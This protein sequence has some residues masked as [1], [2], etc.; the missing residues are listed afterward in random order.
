MRIG[1]EINGVLRNTIGKIEQTYQKFMIDKTEGIE[2]ENSFEYKLSL[3]VTSL[4]LSEHFT[5]QNE[6]EL[7]SFI[8]EEFPMEIF[9]HAQST[10]YTTFN[11]LNELYVKLRDNNDLTIVSDE[12]GKSKPASL[13]FLSKFGCLLE[14]VKFYSNHTIN[15]MWD[16]IDVLLTSNPTLLL[17]CPSN[18]FIIKYETEYNKHINWTHSI[19]TLKELEQ[20]LKE[21]ELC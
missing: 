13:F 2:D 17:E 7:Y 21:M 8:Y 12:M 1:I 9:G 4:N 6:E 20:K 14:K 19:T 16:E 11:D 18:K 15:S 3:P 10:E 5:F